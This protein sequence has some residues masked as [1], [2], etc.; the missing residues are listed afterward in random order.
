M[1]HVHPAPA[2]RTAATS[3]SMA[4]VS[5]LS[6]AD[7]G[8]RSGVM[9]GEAQSGTRTVR[10]PVESRTGTLSWRAVAGRRC[11]PIASRCSLACR[12]ESM[13]RRRAWIRCGFFIGRLRLDQLRNLARHLR[14]RT[15]DLARL[16]RRHRGGNGTPGS[17]GPATRRTACIQ[18]APVGALRDG[19]ACG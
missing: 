6:P 9:T 19:G 12:R 4:T 2:A 16:I 15:K 17:T 1:I 14:F 3:K 8:G 5:R 11:H 18:G 10:E 7:P 13:T